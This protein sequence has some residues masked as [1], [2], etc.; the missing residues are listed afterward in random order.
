MF[1]IS[2]VMALLFLG[3]CF[4]VQNSFENDESLY[5]QRP[6]LDLNDPAQLRLQ[7]ARDVFE[8]YNCISCHALT[9]SL[10]QGFEVYTDSE[11][12]TKSCTSSGGPCV[13]AGSPETSPLYINLDTPDCTRNSA[14]CNMPAGAQKLSQEDADI[15]R[16]W[17]EEL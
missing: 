5:A 14:D 8:Y 11:W 1:R 9:P 15:I 3:G 7:R 12:L 6:Q 10:F 17:I 13:V 2:A 16:E 4:Q